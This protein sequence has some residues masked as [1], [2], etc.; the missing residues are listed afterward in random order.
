VLTNPALAVAHLERLDEQA[1]LLRKALASERHNPK[2][3]L[4]LGFVLID[5]GRVE[6]AAAA[7]EQALALDPTSDDAINLLGRIAFMRGALDAALAH[8]RRALELK[9]NSADLHNRMGH[10]LHSLGRFR[11][12]S[13]AYL[14]ALALDPSDTRIYLN[15]ADTKTFTKDDPHLHAMQAL[16]RDESIQQ[17]ERMYLHFALG[18]AF[19][20]LNDHARAFEYLLQGNA[21]K[22]AQITY[23][24]MA[25]LALFERT[26]VLFTPA[27]IKKKARHGQRSHLPVFILGMPRSGTSLVEQILASH[28]RVFGAGELTTFE[29]VICKER[30]SRSLLPYPDCIPALDAASITQIG[31]HYLAEMRRLAATSTTRVTNKMPSNYLFIG[32]IHMTLPNARIIHT[33]RDPVETCISCF[34][35]LFALEQNYTYDLAEL[36]R[37]YRGYQ[38]LMA[39]WHH[40]LP[41]GRILDVRYEDVVTDLE[42]QARRIIAHCGLDWDERCLAFHQTDRPVRTASAMQVRR[43][44]YTT[45]I[46]RERVYEPF[47]EPLLTALGVGQADVP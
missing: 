33:V 26:K 45:S 17:S 22:R 20:D 34:S 24:E 37:Y 46:R 44:I 8:Y 6:E 14:N 40:A 35:K 12:A 4:R 41:P 11:E 25:T 21:L 30:A 10:V 47:L 39:H 36:G 13:D 19:A 9:P 23:D 15:L 16:E 28:P 32:L 38:R 42:G 29:D 7:L 18:K 5:L 43:P 31:A 1:E 3:Y 27:L 2:L